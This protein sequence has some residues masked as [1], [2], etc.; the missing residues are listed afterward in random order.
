MTANNEIHKQNWNDDFTMIEKQ[1]VIEK[2][3]IGLKRKLQKPLD[4][5]EQDE[6]EGAEAVG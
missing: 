4:P 2:V 5:D 3:M 1:A 6:N